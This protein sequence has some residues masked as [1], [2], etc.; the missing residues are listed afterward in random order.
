MSEAPVSS[1]TPE[2]SEPQSNE[3]TQNPVNS[4]NIAP[5]KRNL[6]TRP[7]IKRLKRNL[8]T[9]KYRIDYHLRKLPANECKKPLQLKNRRNNY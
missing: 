9:M 4:Q 1:P 7:T 8:M 2:S 3:S 5:Q 6:N